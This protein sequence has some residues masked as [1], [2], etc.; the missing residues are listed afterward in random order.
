MIPYGDRV[1][2]HTI[3]A[4]N[5]RP[6]SVLDEIRIGTLTT[7]IG[8]NDTG[9]S[10]VLKALDVFFNNPSLVEDDVHYGADGEDIIIEVTFNSLPTIEIEDGIKT[11]LEEEMLV[12]SRCFLQIQKR[13]PRDNLNKF[14]IILNVFDFEDDVY[15]DLVALTET[16]LNKRCESLGIT[17]SKSGRGVTNRDKRRSIRE[18]ALKEGIPLVNRELIFTK[19]NKVWKKIEKLL[20]NFDLFDTDTELGIR[21]ASFQKEFDQIVDDTAKSMG[22]I[23]ATNAFTKKIE[24]ALQKEVDQIFERFKKLTDDL[25]SFS[26]KPEFTW[27]KAVSFEI[28]GKDHYSVEK[29]IDERGTG[30]RRILMVAFFQHLAE[31]KTNKD[32]FIYGIEEPENSLHPGLQRELIKSFLKLSKGG[33][34]IIVTS[35]SPVFAGCSPM[36]DLVLIKRLKGVAT[37]EQ[38]MDLDPYEVVDELGIEPSDQIIGY[39]ACIFVEGKDDIKFFE[40]I[41]TKLKD[42]RHITNNFE[43]KKIGFIICGGDN[44]KHWVE[45]NAMNKLSRHFGVVIDSD[46][47][48]SADTIRGKKLNW[49]KSCESQGGTFFI[50]KKRAIEN[51]IHP[52]AIERSSGSVPEPYNDFTD[53]KDV[54]GSNTSKLITA[55][56]SDEIL[57][58]DRYE[59]HGVEKHELKEIVETLLDLT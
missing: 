11:T 58:M 33:H 13:Y 55:M 46:L 23:L 27:H 2:I 8:K 41:A 4:K 56:S 35:H 51:Y 53:M 45:L 39:D 17:Y 42:D 1:K 20:S 54:F 57:E 47:K 30:V 31:K 7:I 15:A 48:S 9:K 14:E 29:S 18:K 26:V 49:K 34:Q 37:I 24:I 5:F 22:T 6:F 12:N 21:S 28:M 52:K 50:L 32:K 25:V 40:T 16:N 59:D 44:L 36:D 3:S 43:D 38:S 10:S 19:S